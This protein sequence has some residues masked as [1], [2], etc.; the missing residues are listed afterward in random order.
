M[1]NIVIFTLNNY[2]TYIQSFQIY[3]QIIS[4]NNK[5]KNHTAMYNSY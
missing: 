1:Y 4:I 2:I 5:N 3:L